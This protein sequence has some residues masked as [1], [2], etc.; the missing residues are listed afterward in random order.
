MNDFTTVFKIKNSYPPAPLHAVAQVPWAQVFRSCHQDFPCDLFPS[1]AKH[2]TPA[3]F[4]TESCWG[5]IVGK[6][7][8]C[9]W[10]AESPQEEGTSEN[11]ALVHVFVVVCNQEM[12][13][14]LEVFVLTEFIVYNWIEFEILRE[15]RFCSS[16]WNQMSQRSLK[17]KWMPFPP[18]GMPQISW[19]GLSLGAPAATSPVECRTHLLQNRQALTLGEH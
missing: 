1:K 12:H 14:V 6:V 17:F 9:C 8:S 11:V 19:E 2:P 15:N 13:W 18:F 7:S 10:E 3:G 4:V 16:L 5:Q